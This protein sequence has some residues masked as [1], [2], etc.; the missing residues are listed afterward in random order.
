[1]AHSQSNSATTI[2]FG[3]GWVRGRQGQGSLDW[4]YPYANPRPSLRPNL[5]L[6]RLIWSRPEA[7]QNN[8]SGWRGQALQPDAAR[9]LAATAYC[10]QIA[11][12]L[13]SF[14]GQP[15]ARSLEYRAT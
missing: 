8:N 2:R 3:D 12:D 11:S 13:G 10:P 5:K 9:L 1:M 4:Q 15:L 7:E 14:G 6:K